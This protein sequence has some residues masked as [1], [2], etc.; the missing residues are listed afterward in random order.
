MVAHCLR[1]W[2]F[3]KNTLPYGA[4]I[5]AI[6]AVENSKNPSCNE[7][8]LKM[9]N[10]LGFKIVIEFQYNFRNPAFFRFRLTTDTLA[11]D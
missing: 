4:V 7:H 1:A 3:I 10:P 2:T 9:L 8:Y 5:F 6:F 11:F